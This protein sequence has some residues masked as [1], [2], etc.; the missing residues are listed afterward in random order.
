FELFFQGDHIWLLDKATQNGTKVP[1]GAVVKMSDSGQVKVVDDEGNEHWL[2]SP[3]T[4]IKVM[5]PTSVEGVEDMIRLGDLNEAGILRNLLIRYN[6]DHIY[7]FTGSILVAVNP[8]QELPLYDIDAIR[9]YTKRKLGEPPHIFAIAD[10]AYN[11]MLRS[12]QDQ[13]VIVSGESGAGKTESTKLVLQYL[14]AISGQHSWIEQQIL[15]ANPILEAF[16]N[17]KTI[18][19]DNS[20]RFGKFIDIRFNQDG[21]IQSAKIDQYLLEKSRLVHQTTDERNY[22][23][24]YCMLAG[25]A[26]NKK[27]ELG[28]GKPSEYVNLTQGSCLQ[29]AGRNDKEEYGDIV[30]GMKVCSVAILI[31]YEIFRLLAGILH[32]GNFQFR[33]TM[34]DN[35]DSVE[36]IHNSGVKRT[37]QLLGVN[38]QSLMRALTQRTIITREDT[39]TSPM[40]LEQS[41]DVKDA[42]IKGIYGRMFVWIVDKINSAIFKDSKTKKKHWNTIGL[43]DIFGF[44]NFGNNSFEQLCINFANE[45]LQQFFVRHVFKLEQ[46][47]YNKEAIEWKHITFKDNQD[48]LDMIAVKPMNILALISEEAMFPRV[49]NLI[50]QHGKNILFKNPKNQFDETF[51]IEHFAGAVRYSCAGF[52]ERNRDTFHRDLMNLIQGSKNKFLKL[53]FYQDSGSKSNS[54]RRNHT[55]CEQ[56]KKSLDSLMRTLSACQPFFVRCIKPNETKS[57]HNF[58][59]EL[60][61]RQL[62]YSGMMETIRIRRAGYPIRY[63]F[64]EFI[65]R[66][67]MT[68]R[69]IRPSKLENDHIAGCK[70][71]I[72]EALGENS[73]CQVGKTKVFL[74]DAHDARLEIA[75]DAAISRW[76]I[77]IQRAVRGWYCRHRYLTQRKSAIRI[78][79]A[80]RKYTVQKQYFVIK[81]GYSRLQALWRARRLAFR[82]NFA[83]KR[84]IRF[85]VQCR[86]FL[87]RKNVRHKLWAIIKI[88]SC[89]RGYIA[90]QEYRKLKNLRKVKKLPRGQQKVQNNKIKHYE[91]MLYISKDVKM[92]KKKGLSYGRSSG[93]LMS[94][95]R[96]K[97]SLA[98]D[99]TEMVDKIFGYLDLEDGNGEAADT[100]I[101]H[102]EEKEDISEYKFSKFAAT[103]FQANATNAHTKR[104]LKTP[105]LHHENEGDKMAS[106]AVWITILRFMGDLPEPVKRDNAPKR[107]NVPVMNKIHDTLGRSYAKNAKQIEEMHSTESRRRKSSSK[108]NRLISMTLKKKSKLTGEVANKLRSGEDWIDVINSMVMDRPTTNLE[109]LHF[110]IGNGILRPNIR[111]EIYCQICKQLTNNVFKS[112]HSRGWILLSLCVGCFAPNEDFV[113]YLQNFIRGGPLN[114]A[115]YCE[116]RLLRT[117]ANGPRSQP[118]SWLE[119]QATKSRKMIMLPITFMDGATNTFLADSAT[120]AK[121]LCDVLAKKIGLTDQFGF[122]LYIALFDKVSSLGSSG[123]HVMDAISQCEQYAKEQGAQEKHAQWRLF[124]RKEIF[125]PWHD[126]C[127]D[128]VSTTLIYQQIVRGVKFNEYRCNTDLEL[129]QL[130]SKQYYVEH[131]ASIQTTSLAPL[132]SSYLPDRIVTSQKPLSHWSSMIMKQHKEAIYTRERWEPLRVREDV[133][134]QARFSWP[135]MFS[136]FYEAYRLS[137]LPLP[138]NEVLI[139]VNWTGVFFLDDQEQVLLELPFAEMTGITANKGSEKMK[140][141][142]ITVTTVRGDA[143]TMTSSSSDDVCELVNLF[144]DGLKERSR[145]VVTLNTNPN[146]VMDESS[147]LKFK[148]GDLLVLN[149]PAGADFNSSAWRP[150]RNERTGVSGDFPTDCVYVI[151]TLVKPLDDLV[152]MFTMSPGELAQHGRRVSKVGDNDFDLD[153]KP[154]TLE[155]YADEFFRAPIPQTINRAPPSRRGKEKLYAMSREPIKQ[156]LLKKLEHNHDM[157]QEAITPNLNYFDLNSFAPIMKYMGDYPSKKQRHG[158]EQT[159]QIFEAPLKHEQLR[160]EVFCQI[161]KQLTNNKQSYSEERGWELMWLATGVFAPSNQLMPHLHKFLGT[162]REN[163]M[164][165]D[166]YHRYKRPTTHG[167]RKY[168]PH[169][170]E[171][172]AI[173][174]KTTQIFHKVYFPDDTDEARIKFFFQAFE[175]ESST[176]AKDFCQNIANRL[177]LKSADGFSLFVKIADKVI[178]VPENDFFFDFV[179]HLTDW[180]KKAR[181][182]KDG[183]TPTLT[184]QVFFMKKLW[185]TTKPGKDPNADNIFHYFQE[186]PKYLRGYHKCSKEDA[187]E[188]AALIYRVQFGDDKS[189]FPNIPRMLKELAPLFLLRQA[190]P[191]DWKRNIVQHYNKSTIRTKDEAKLAFL[192]IIFKWKTFG[193]A[194]FEVR[195]TTEPSFPENLIIAINKHGVSLIDP[196]TKTVLVTYH[197]AKISNWS[198]GN[199]YFHMT[200]GNLVKGNKLLCET[201]LGYKMD[202]LLT[203]YISLMLNMVQKNSKRKL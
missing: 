57:A 8:Y 61:A 18:R 171:V 180:L 150:G 19:N 4:N 104:Q 97:M 160:D 192:N 186:K 153:E 106:L 199:S 113:K 103:Y 37:A 29:C 88:Q 174:H 114:Y 169:L 32:T 83:R 91:C 79:S 44:E 28:L 120:T 55:L 12:K 181:P 26:A 170:V 45:N 27:Q 190:S 178:S 116:Q 81:N 6:E 56:F 48:V 65:D 176:R 78:Q 76:V 15:E 68:V 119:L 130:A 154:Y 40:N 179:R 165:N 43:L 25:M 98:I 184:Y 182:T 149:Q 203:S 49:R 93:Y 161:M 92:L 7:T 173:Q 141:A 59:R 64:S 188:L 107:D 189:Q 136:R 115:P 20:S 71:I 163:P 51:G 195:Q 109:K 38:E 10:N 95:K 46:E 82:Y 89:I 152:N 134:K 80:W 143:L 157:T 47:E 129:A 183:S 124:Y 5:H 198:S 99:H 127:I 167:H 102:M 96:R 77:V 73:D 193:S 117:F 67:R 139:A 86:G 66:Y 84:I 177:R 137:G 200:I 21:I 123:D 201:S 30:R 60:V 70:R 131:G 94:E 69:G 175:V 35:L 155:E 145:Y 100:S 87:A 75:R 133:V 11:N 135:M 23:V 164:A 151:P 9:K 146:K 1:L 122:S 148:K 112:S 101:P 3:L 16:G 194:F 105:L 53:L 125:T 39:V 166:C 191:D 196:K 58:D 52:L 156:P 185:A 128:K 54:H 36:L 31:I 63:S 41:N 22:H 17:A 24:F 74:K 111:N 144:I 197:F 202:D 138:T 62:R 142:T 118:P 72:S 187:Y 126:P 110:I 34:T 168:P 14:A 50:R 159:D 13:C 147:I 42:F 162:R 172:E 2:K 121:E 158:N 108:Q 90:R 132:I 140:A 33:E 85:Q